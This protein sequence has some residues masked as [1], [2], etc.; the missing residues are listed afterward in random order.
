[1]G[2]GSSES[3]CN[4]STCAGDCYGAY[5]VLPSDSSWLLL[6]L[7][8]G[9]F[10]AVLTYVHWCLDPVCLVGNA[11]LIAAFAQD[12]AWR[13]SPQM[14]YLFNTACNTASIVAYLAINI[15]R[16]CHV[17]AG[18]EVEQT[19]GIVASWEVLV[20]RTQGLS[21][22][23]LL[24]LAE[25]G[26]S[27]ALVTN[28]LLCAERSLVVAL[29]LRSAR[30]VT[31]RRS[32]LVLYGSFACNTV[33]ALVPYFFWCGSFFCPILANFVLSTWLGALNGAYMFF[34]GPLLSLSFFSSLLSLQHY[35]FPI[36]V[37]RPV[38]QHVRL[39]GGEPHS[40]G[41]GHRVHS[42]AHQ[43]AAGRAPR[44]TRDDYAERQ[45][46]LQVVRAI[47]RDA[48]RPARRSDRSVHHYLPVR[49]C[50]PASQY[51]IV[52]YT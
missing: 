16:S 33:L 15:L 44:A 17:S 25:L 24:T 12:A 11:M 5:C 30:I 1:M 48:D 31:V 6:G 9:W 47:A 26:R 39:G 23:N 50:L 38:P 29:P 10:Q 28:G 45:R 18:F 52:Q 37:R 22:H 43:A 46:R 34:T 13:R 3:Y 49:T 41:A 19:F 51:S 4:L 32:C 7:W 35:S 8:T 36:L 20:G 2:G 21:Y 40:S 42:G 14:Y 27:H